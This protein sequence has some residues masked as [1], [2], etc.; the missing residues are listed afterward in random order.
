M[1]DAVSQGAH[2]EV[3]GKRS[4]VGKNFYEPTLIRNVTT[5]MLCT[6]EET[7]GPLAPVIK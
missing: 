7:F 6:R 5:K 4:S 3:G 2:I 1:Q